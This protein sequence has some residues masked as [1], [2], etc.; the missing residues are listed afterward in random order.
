VDTVDANVLFDEHDRL[1]AKFVLPETDKE[2]PSLN[3][4]AA[5]TAE[6]QLTTP[7]TEQLDRISRGPVSRT[8]SPSNELA[9]EVSDPTWHEAETDRHE[10]AIES[11]VTEIAPPALAVLAQDIDEPT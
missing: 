1:S 3:L 2:E 4:P 10:P 7:V 6:A 9:I 11:P 5:D 8:F